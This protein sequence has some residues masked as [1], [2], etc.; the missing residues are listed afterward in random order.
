MKEEWKDIEG[1]QG[2]Y[3]ISSKGRVYS[4][5]NEKYLTSMKASNDYLQVRLFWDR[6]HYKQLLVHRLVF[7]HFVRKIKPNEEV[8]HLDQNKQNNDVSNLVAMDCGQHRRLH[9]NGNTYAKGKKNDQWKRK[10]SISKI[11]FKH[12][13]QTKAKISAANLGRKHTEQAKQKMRDA[14]KLR[15]IKK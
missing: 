15:K 12:S 3:R 9:M 11:G 10:I 1:F 2:L 5:I 14:W 6:E 7:E 13:E 4:V 8:H